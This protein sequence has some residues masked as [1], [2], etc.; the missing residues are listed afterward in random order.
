MV[1]KR[2]MVAFLT[3]L[4]VIFPKLDQGPIAVGS[5]NMFCLEASNTGCEMSQLL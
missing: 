1:M 4:R 5:A 2:P 3:G